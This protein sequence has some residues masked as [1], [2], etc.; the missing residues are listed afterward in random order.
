MFHGMIGMGT[1]LELAYKNFEQNTK[2][3]E[4]L[5]N[6]YLEQIEKRIPNI[7]LNGDKI[8]RLVGNANISF[9]GVDG[10]ELLLKLDE[11]G[12]CASAG[13]ACSTGSTLPSHVLTAIGLT[14]EDAM[15]ALR[16]T[17]GRENT[18][19]DIDYL[20]DHLEKIVRELRN[21]K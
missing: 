14:P 11:K 10:E 13:S 5:R 21:K 2:H 15:G 19:E 1:A 17:F 16:T 7:K 12:M 6:Y 4:N 18:K 3:L 9:M 20:V 8:K